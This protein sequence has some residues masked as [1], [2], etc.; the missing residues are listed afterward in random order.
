MAK[1]RAG[2]KY[3][4]A[5]AAT[6]ARRRVETAS[7]AS[8]GRPRRSTRPARLAFAA[9]PERAGKPIEKAGKPIEKAGKPIEKAGK[10]IEKAGKPIEKGTP[11]QVV[12]D[13]FRQVA[14]LGGL[15]VVAMV[16]SIGASRDPG[17]ATNAVTTDDEAL[18]LLAELREAQTLAVAQ[19]LFGSD[20]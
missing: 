19:S 3:N 14:G 20:D 9:L 18:A 8:I 6:L 10:P 7:G 15:F 13:V 2:R 12:E 4:T 16:T 17:S 5:I 11:E 1:K